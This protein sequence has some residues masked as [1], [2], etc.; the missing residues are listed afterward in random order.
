MPYMPIKSA[1]REKLGQTWDNVPLFVRLVV[2]FERNLQIHRYSVSM[3]L[4]D[5]F[6]LL[7]LFKY[8]RVA[9]MINIERLGWILNV[10]CKSTLTV[11]VSFGGSASTPILC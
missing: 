7:V 1:T 8:L 3:V 5:R 9:K 11:L 2:D 4:E 10:F 6:R